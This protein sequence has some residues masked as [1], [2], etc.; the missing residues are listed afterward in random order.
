MF[1]YIRGWYDPKKLIPKR[2]R[3]SKS[4]LIWQFFEFLRSKKFTHKVSPYSDIKI[5]FFL[6]NWPNPIHTGHWK[7]MFTHSISQKPQQRPKNCRLS[8]LLTILVK[9]HCHF[10]TG[11]L[12]AFFYFYALIFFTFVLATMFVSASFLPK[13]SKVKEREWKLNFGLRN[14]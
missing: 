9:N 14:W 11:D 1:K 3:G 13:V 4:L 10:I 2:L 8:P 12:K 7:D 5:V 6:K